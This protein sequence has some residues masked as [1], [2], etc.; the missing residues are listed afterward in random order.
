M[1][2]KSASK[3]ALNQ[4]DEPSLEHF[5]KHFSP[6]PG[7]NHGSLKKKRGFYLSDSEFEFLKSKAKVFSKILNRKVTISEANR[8]LIF[9]HHELQKVLGQFKV[10][11][12][13][14]ETKQKK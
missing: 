6:Y 3:D 8:L 9:G 13:K 11:L 4:K 12:E 5:E 10:F 1:E 2:N 14:L 7:L